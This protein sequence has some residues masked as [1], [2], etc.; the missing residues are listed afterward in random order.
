MTYD[1][2]IEAWNAQADHMNHWPELSEQEKVEWARQCA[3]EEAAKVCMDKACK[4]KFEY[5]YTEKKGYSATRDENSAT[6]WALMNCA[7]DILARK[8]QP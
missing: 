4:M 5:V 7:R 3:L 2:I 8:G 1:Q 6:A